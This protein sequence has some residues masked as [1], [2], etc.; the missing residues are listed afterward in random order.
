MEA[1]AQ[2]KNAGQMVVD[3]GIPPLHLPPRLPFP[4]GITNR[5]PPPHPT[6]VSARGHLTF[7]LR[8]T[9]SAFFQLS[10]FLIFV[11][12]L[13]AD[14]GQSK[15]IAPA[16]AHPHPLCSPRT[17]PLAPAPCP[18]WRVPRLPLRAGGLP[19]L[20]FAPC[21]AE[22]P[23]PIS[24]PWPRPYAMGPSHTINVAAPVCAPHG[25]NNIQTHLVR[26]YYV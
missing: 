7:S 9:P 23:C 10:E 1:A 11:F 6:S 16:P 4:F 14:G 17:R 13:R 2:G 5:K 21:P 18:R 15:K 22:G 8:F 3:A 24:Q 25:I 12:L 19:A 20:R 26:T